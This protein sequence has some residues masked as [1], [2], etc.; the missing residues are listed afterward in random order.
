VRGTHL[1]PGMKVHVIG[2]GDYHMLEIT[3]LADPCP[4]PEKERERTVR[5]LW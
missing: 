5:L 3:S 2:V 4:I 1:K